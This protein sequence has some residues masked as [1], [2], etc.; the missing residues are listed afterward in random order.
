MKRIVLILIIIFTCVGC[1]N[2]NSNDLVSKSQ[3]N[4]DS[5]NSSYIQTDSVD[6]N[7]KKQSFINPDGM[8]I[9]TR[10][11]LPEGFDRTIGNEYENY[12]RNIEL[13]P[14]NSPV[15]LYDGSKKSNQNVHLAVLNIDVGNKN[16]QQCADSALRIRC[17]YLFSTQNFDQINYHLTNGFEFPYIKYR[18]GY[19]LKINGNN[20]WL[21]KS[22]SFD[23]SYDTFRNYLETLF[24]YAGTRSLDNESKSISK[25]EM[26]IGDIFI[27]GG[28]PGH[29]V[30]VM[31]ICINENG[32]KMFILGQGYMPAQQ[33]HILKNSDSNNPWYSLNNLEYPFR[34]PEYTFDN[35]CLKRMP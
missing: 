13:L 17:E 18:E 30:I 16:L 2:G 22:S 27:K 26:Q 21:E 14:D 33:I 10:F 35:K 28:S 23:D 34:T 1:A 4:Y 20:T 6:S 32:D 11:L 9:S 8:Q 7:L 31:D 29:C 5:E 12:I 15:I 19:R 3:S 25:E 24:C